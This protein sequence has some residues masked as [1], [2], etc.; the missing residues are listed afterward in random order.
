MRGGKF[1]FFNTQNKVFRSAVY[2]GGGDVRCFL[3]RSR[4]CRACRPDQ[5]HHVDLAVECYSSG[6][7]AERVQPLL[8]R[9]GDRRLLRQCRGL[10]GSRRY[11]HAR[12]RAFLCEFER[13]AAGGRALAQAG[14]RPAS[15]TAH[16][17][18]AALRAHLRPGGRFFRPDRRRLCHLR[19]WRQFLRHLFHLVSGRCAV[20]HYS[21]AGARGLPL[22]R[23][24]ECRTR[25][26]VCG[27][28]RPA[29]PLFYG[30]RPYFLFRAIPAAVSR[31]PAHPHSDLPLRL[32]RRRIGVADGSDLFH[33]GDGVGI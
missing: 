8:A 28:P 11:L 15:D 32:P 22:P 16:I 24:R 26:E 20:A 25:Q 2:A 30:H 13:S 27:E 7:L 6:D 29:G 4:L 31:L 9:T 12:H 21:D 3:R 18:G 19:L 33:F 1:V 5:R 14:S 10:S 17:G 23:T